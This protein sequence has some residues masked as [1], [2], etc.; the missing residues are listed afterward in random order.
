MNYS[1]ASTVA[2]DNSVWLQPSEGV[3]RVCAKLLQSC[4]TL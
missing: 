3:A 1:A 2:W 4:L